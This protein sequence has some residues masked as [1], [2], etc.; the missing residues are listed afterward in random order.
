MSFEEGVGQATARP[1]VAIASARSRVD[2]R[3][4][5]GG[6]TTEDGPTGTRFEGDFERADAELERQYQSGHKKG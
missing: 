2:G 5:E 1:F 4:S 6:T 3:G